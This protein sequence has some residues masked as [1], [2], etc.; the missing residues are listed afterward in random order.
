[1][2]PDVTVRVQPFFAP[3]ISVVDRYV[4][5]FSG[6]VGAGPYPRTLP[7]PEPAVPP[8]TGGGVLPQLSS[9]TSASPVLT[10]GDSLT[11]TLAVPS[12]PPL[13]APSIVFQSNEGTRPYVLVS[14]D[15]AAGGT[16]ATAA[17]L[18]PA[19]L[20]SDAKPNQIQID[21]IWFASADDNG[22]GDFVIERAAA[23]GQS[24]LDWDQILIRHCTF[25][26][27]GERAD[28]SPIIPLRLLVAGRV[29]QLII[30]RSILASIVVQP[31]DATHPGG[32]IEELIIVDSI[33]DAT[34]AQPGAGSRLVAIDDIDGKVT[35]RGVTVFGDI[36]AGVLDA[37]DTLVAGQIIVAN[38]Q[39][40]CFRFSAASPGPTSRPLPKLFNAVVTQEIEPFFFTSKVFGDPG[41][42]QLSRVAPAAVAAGAENASEMGAFSF[43]LSPIHLASIIAKVD[44]FGPLGLLAQY[45]LEDE[46][47][48]VSQT[49]T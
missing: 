34:H 1:V 41:Y 2:F 12:A 17:S 40:S 23:G 43:L 25:D 48:P 28:G 22:I 37:T 30:T 19:S 4:Y 24:G 44:E 6:P 9:L 27:G 10:I 3:P 31:A 35:L 18:T 29:R 5:G 49:N 14:G 20:S 39:S 15:A 46:T 38:T 36:R 11:Y 8:V 13:A 42:A 33:V 47:R 32:L 45:I 21:G 16:S 7:V 26:P